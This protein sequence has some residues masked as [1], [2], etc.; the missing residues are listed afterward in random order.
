MGMVTIT[1]LL[2]LPESALGFSLGVRAHTEMK[3]RMV[4]KGMYMLSSFEGKI[5]ELIIIIINHF[6]MFCVCMPSLIM[7]CW[8]NLVASILHHWRLSV[9]VQCPISFHKSDVFVC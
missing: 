3:I 8:H 2:I 4:I 5:Q 1:S 9:M 7:Q 6:H